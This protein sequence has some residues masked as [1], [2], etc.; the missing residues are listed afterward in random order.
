MRIWRNADPNAYN[1]I[2]QGGAQSGSQGIN[3]PQ[4]FHY[5]LDYNTLNMIP[6]PGYQDTQNY[7][8]QAVQQPSTQT[9]ELIQRMTDMM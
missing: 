1:Q 5:S 3:V 6:N 2:L 8:P 9:D 4:G 7:S